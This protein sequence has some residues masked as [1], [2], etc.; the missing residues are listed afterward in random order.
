MSGGERRRVQLARALIP[1]L[2]LLLRKSGVDSLVVTGLTTSGCVRA[3]AVDGLQYDYP[4]VVVREAVGDRNMQAHTANLFDIHAKYADVMAL[5]D[6][7]VLL[8]AP[9]A[10]GSYCS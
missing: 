7:L 1:D 3:T 8:P 5:A 6:V 4:V 9:A 10:P 2:D